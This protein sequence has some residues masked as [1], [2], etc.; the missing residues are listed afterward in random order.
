MFTLT[1]FTAVAI[2]IGFF[3]GTFWLATA[4]TGIVFA[5]LFPLVAIFIVLTAFGLA[6]LRLY[7]RW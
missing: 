1:I 5:K 3:G 6:A 4:V 2:L 7:R